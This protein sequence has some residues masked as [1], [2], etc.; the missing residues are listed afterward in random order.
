MGPALGH[1]LQARQRIC[2]IYSSCFCAHADW[3]QRY[4]L[5]AEDS[6]FQVR[7]ETPADFEV[8]KE[9]AQ[10]KGPACS[11]APP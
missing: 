1:W 4:R 5:R 9:W 7:F 11:S 8:P 3:P 6:V 10:L 2:K